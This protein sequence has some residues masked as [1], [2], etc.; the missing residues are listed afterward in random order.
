MSS[1]L[2]E[3]TSKR[4]RRRYH[5]LQRRRLAANCSSREKL[6]HNS[7]GN[8][9][10]EDPSDRDVELWRDLFCQPRQTRPFPST[11]ILSST[12]VPNTNDKTNRETADIERIPLLQEFYKAIGVSRDGADQEEDGGAGREDQQQQSYEDD[13]D[14]PSLSQLSLGQHRRY[15]QLKGNHPST[16]RRT[17]FERKEWKTLQRLV[18][19]EQ[20][21][22]QRALAR[23]FQ[24][25][26]D[27]FGIGFLSN[28]NTLGTSLARFSQWA[29]SNRKFQNQQQYKSLL[30]PTDATKFGSCR[31]YLSLQAAKA[32]LSS[33]NDIEGLGTFQVLHSSESV[34]QNNCPIL[35]AFPEIG[36]QIS[37]PRKKHTAKGIVSLQDDTV[38]HEL[39]A[40]HN[41]NILTTK[42]M[43]ETVL[44]RDGDFSLTQWMAR[45]TSTSGKTSNCSSFVML[46]TPI[47]QAFSSPR[48]CL[49]H[50][51]QEALYQQL[52]GGD[53][54]QPQHVRYMYT[55]WTLPKSKQQQRRRPRGKRT[56]TVEN[57]ILV[58]STIRLRVSNDDEHNLL[59]LIIRVHLEYFPERGIMEVPSSYERSL[60]ILDQLVC[61]HQVSSR[62]CRIDPN[63][64]KVLAWEEASVA[65]AVCQ[66]SP[67]EGGR[68]PISYHFPAVLQLFQS[69]HLLEFSSASPSSPFKDPKGD[70]ASD[71]KSDL[72]WLVCSLRQMRVSVHL[73]CQDTNNAILDL[74]PIVESSDTIILNDTSLRQ[75]SRVWKWDRDD[76]IPYTFP[77]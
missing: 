24:V 45:C 41:V 31:Q 37:P 19:S 5:P 16:N 77:K 49:R 18:Q 48:D 12:I 61:Q 62:L 40:K 4:S 6:D 51:F 56:P 44:L 17:E 42:E 22:Y 72:F 57:R 73:P 7:N 68:D 21:E 53:A 28:K 52:R 54:D 74:Q 50:G 55:M 66:T 63:T 23:F 20:K 2:D 46:D 75:C 59:P 70:N 26:K 3:P 1:P 15:L 9:Y 13:I 27:R 11:Q 47:K 36:S 69:I 25:H 64:C 67:A 71:E 76:R 32:S 58:R 34:D 14:N 8:I 29:S 10:E 65:Y 60:W 33:V 38:A 30:R 39:A 35:E 43:L